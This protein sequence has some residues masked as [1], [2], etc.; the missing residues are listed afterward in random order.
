MKLVVLRIEKSQ[1]FRE[2]NVLDESIKRYLDQRTLDIGP[3]HFAVFC[4]CNRAYT[5]EGV[6]VFCFF[7][8]LIAV[9]VAAVGVGVA[10][11]GIA[12][13]VA[14][15][16]FRI[17]LLRSLE[18]L[19]HLG[20]KLFFAETSELLNLFCHKPGLEF[21]DGEKHQLRLLGAGSNGLRPVSF[22]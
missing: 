17:R 14:R 2:F 21:L 6:A 22:L 9:A 10:V 19:E 3:K 12:V 7:C 5:P 15:V 1:N 11:T 20:D 4:A 8:Y 16:R 13:R 18:L